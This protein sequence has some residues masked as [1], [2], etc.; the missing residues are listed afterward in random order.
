MSFKDIPE[1]RLCINLYALVNK[2]NL[3]HFKRDPSRLRYEC[4]GGCHSLLISGDK[5]LLGVRVKTLK[6]THDFDEVFD[7]RR[8]DHLTI[9]YY[10]KSKLQNDPTYRIKVLRDDLKERFDVMLV[11]VSA[12]EQSY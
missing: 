2:R 6:N 1:Y 12:I 10:F 11:M 8:V 5:Y 4:V 9:A 7:N 3:K